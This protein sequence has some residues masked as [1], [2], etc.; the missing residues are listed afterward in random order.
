MKQI[1]SEKDCTSCMACYSVC[2]IR[3]IRIVTDQDGFYRP[4][5]DTKK[6]I[7]CKRCLHVCPVHGHVKKSQPHVAIA[8]YAK[9]KLL[10]K[11]STS[12]GAFTVIATH[13]IQNGG[14]VF[15]AAYDKDFTVRHMWVDTV[16]ALAKF[17]TSKY[18]QSCIGK[19][20]QEVKEFLSTG[21]LVFFT[22]TPCQVNGLL[23]Y[24][25]KTYANLLTADIVCH[26]TPTP[27]FFKEYLEDIEK[28]TGR[29]IDKIRFRYKTTDYKKI[30][31]RCLNNMKITLDDGE[32]YI[33][34]S[35]SDPY[36]LGYFS[37]LFL[38]PA[39]YHC[40]FTTRQR[41]GD[42]TLGDFWGF[43]APSLKWVNTGKGISLIL[44]NT[45]KGEKIFDKIKSQL[46]WCERPIMEAIG[47]NI[48]LSHSMEK[49]SRYEIFWQD[50]RLYGYKYVE[51][52]YFSPIPCPK[53]TLLETVKKEIPV[54]VK[55]IL[56]KILRKE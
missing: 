4:Q 55:W 26:G 51:K 25:G 40:L 33:R 19:C 20:F 34:D 14:V 10:R 32:I 13:V 52:K 44:I 53:D 56:K 41:V 21:R 24:L 37:D 30:G 22:G 17:R 50:Y 6:C 54:H 43:K 38:N 23:N 39:C 36:L 28:Q 15:G 7:G 48:P 27:K 2:P 18:V 35:N 12:G 9:D 16:E 46:N 45:D 5:I 47:K 11:Q 3:A 42:I 8:A 1:C 29:K 31:E 49:G